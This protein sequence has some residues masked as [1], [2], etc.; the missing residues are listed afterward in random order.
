MA[1][2]DLSPSNSRPL[3]FSRPMFSDAVHDRQIALC[4]SFIGS[5]VA[6]HHF[7]SYCKGANITWDYDLSHW[8]NNASKLAMRRPFFYLLPWDCFG[9]P[10]VV[11]SFI[12]PGAADSHWVSGR[13]SSKLI[14]DIF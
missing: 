13:P 5:E 2:L 10:A 12:G 14:P 9:S 11:V 8:Y 3:A 6:A 1:F 7:I 4:L